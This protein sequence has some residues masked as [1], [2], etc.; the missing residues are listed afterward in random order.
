[1]DAYIGE[2]RMFAGSFAPQGWLFCDGQILSIAQHTSLFALLGV[3]YGGNGATTF[4]LP[5]LRGRVPI[6]EGQGQYLS[7]YSLGEAG[8]AEHLTLM[9]NQIPAVGIPATSQII[10]QNTGDSSGGDIT[11]L[12]PVP[13][14]Q[15]FYNMQPFLAINFIIAVSGEFPSREV[16]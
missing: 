4:A 13:S 11:V 6:G 9:P 14:Q 10:H 7:A 2:I 16:N 5:D 8:G 1:M 15:P 3:T 12:S